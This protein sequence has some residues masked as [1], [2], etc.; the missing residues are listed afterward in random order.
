MRKIKIL[1]AVFLA[2]AVTVSLAACG[3]KGE[4]KAESGT[5]AAAGTEKTGGT[6]GSAPETEGAK[7]TEGVKDTEEGD[8][9]KAAG[10]AAHPGIEMTDTF[11]FTDPADLDFDTR[12]VF[13]GDSTC[14]LL[15]DMLNYDFHGT[16][17]YEILYVKDG[18]GVGEYQYF[19]MEDEESAK[20]LADFYGAQG[21]NVTQ[22]ENRVY[23]FS[24][25][26]LLKSTLMML[27]GANMIR[28]EE[29]ETY[30]R[31]IADS[32]GLVEQ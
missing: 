15:T 1:T 5:E 7:D 11:T 4:Q 2:A 20:G 23:T 30:V 18:E 26:D 28:D 21:Q 25:A 3:G 24:D 22:E 32:Y 9:T 13:M 27:S 6:E 8:E 19:V 16:A 17:L 31:Y 10:A 14:K 29:P 12:Y